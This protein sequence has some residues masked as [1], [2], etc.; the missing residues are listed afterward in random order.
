M[1]SCYACVY[2]A[3]TFSATPP[4]WSLCFSKWYN[5][6]RF[7]ISVHQIL[8]FFPIFVRLF[9]VSLA[10]FW[11]WL[12]VVFLY[13]SVNIW[14]S[15]TSFAVHIRFLRCHIMYALLFSSFFFSIFIFIFIF[16]F[17]LCCTR[18]LLDSLCTCLATFRSQYVYEC[19]CKMRTRSMCVIFPIGIANGIYTQQAAIEAIIHTYLWNI[20]FA[21]R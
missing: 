17:F 21:C 8:S 10:V 16:L 4:I 20:T 6:A 9:S 13:L 19:D 1:L 12:F 7:A 5:M 3:F 11:W 14:S 15:Y 2:G 18:E